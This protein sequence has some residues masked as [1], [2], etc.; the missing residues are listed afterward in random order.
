MAE[1]A[2]INE[3]LG[4]D[5]IDI[6]MGCPA[7]KIVSNESGSALMK[8]EDLAVK[9]AEAVVKAVK[10]PVTLK[11]RLGWDASNINCLSLA[12]KFEDVGIRA[13]AIHCRTRAQ[14]YSG[15]ADWSAITELKDIV[16]IPY[17]CNGDIKS[18]ED[19]TRALQESRANG[20]MIGR[21]ALGRPW[22]PNQIMKFL[23]EGKI[24]PSPPLEEQLKIVMEHFDAVLDF[25]GKDRGVKLFRKH[26]CWY[27]GGLTGSSNFREIINRA[28]DVSFIKNYAR[29]FYEERFK[30]IL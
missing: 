19:A 3:N 29:D 25:Y 22:L 15:K 6:N 7:R 18:G 9:I 21:A 24:L 13:L 26:F 8:D 20:V 10:I 27:S 4:A 28:E 5:A 16:K 30:A 23:D 12:E 17:L 14:M 2:I 11:M 1:S